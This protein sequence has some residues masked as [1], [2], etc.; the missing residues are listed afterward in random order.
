MAPH[1]IR[2]EGSHGPAHVYSVGAM[3][4]E[5]LTGKPPFEADDVFGF[6]AMHLKE[7]GRPITERFP[8]L[9]VPPELDAIVL[10][11]LE[12]EPKD[13]P[14]DA[15]ALADEIARFAVED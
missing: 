14:G 6:V 12:K 10:R 3:L 1:Q 13:R 2:G 7:R 9:E 8:Q 11:M 4:H 5:L 15:T